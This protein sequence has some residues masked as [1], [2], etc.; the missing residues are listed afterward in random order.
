[1]LETVLRHL[2]NWFE[3][4]GAARYGVCRIVSGVLET[5]NDVKLMDGQYYKID[6][7]VFNDGLHKVCEADALR[8]EE[9]VG[10][11]TPLAIPKEVVELSKEIEKW[12][13][14]NPE[15]DKVSESFGGYSYLRGGSGTAVE[16]GW[17]AAFKT[18]LNDWKKVG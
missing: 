13:E 15:T 9:F 7:S 18:R 1:M 12:R 2:H 11:I 17:Q 4:R 5:E 3:V 8:D 14:D 6:G 16:R 10:T